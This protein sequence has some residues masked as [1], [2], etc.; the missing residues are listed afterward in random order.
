MRLA[1]AMTALHNGLQQ[2][3]A[4]APTDEWRRQ[5]SGNEHAE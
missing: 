5:A 1:A 2:N 3:E 4:R